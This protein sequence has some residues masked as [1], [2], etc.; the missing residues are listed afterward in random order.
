ME[1]EI[2][3]PIARPRNGLLAML[4]Q[5]EFT[6]V[7]PH[8][9][10]A[11][12]AAGEILDTSDRVFFIERGVSSMTL[13]GE[14]LGGGVAMIGAEG[15]LGISHVLGTTALFAYRALA[16]LKAHQMLAADLHRLMSER[17]SFREVATKY[18]GVLLLQVAEQGVCVA[19]KTLIS[20]VARWILMFADRLECSD[21][22][23]THTDI[24]QALSV[25]RAGITDSLHVLEGDHGI[26]AK[27][28]MIQVRSREKLIEAAKGSYGMPGAEYHRVFTPCAGYLPVLDEASV[29]NG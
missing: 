1:N 26:S 19:K 3:N 2:A 8:L 13:D 27:R 22:H 24:A 6:F 25:R 9:D 16:P 20:R 29:R 23:I 15:M 12:F 21:L 11:D 5:P 17:P 10:V 7:R 18:A 4:A 28:G 14:V